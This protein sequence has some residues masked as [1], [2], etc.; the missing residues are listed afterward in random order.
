MAHT[1]TPFFVGTQRMNKEAIKSALAALST[2]DLLEKSKYLLATID[3][4]SERT[5]ALS[6]TVDDFFEE[7][8]AL[9]PNTKTEQ[10]FSK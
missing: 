6:G 4:R 9:N 1:A 10:E 3:Y 5:L 2:G 7:F 8:P